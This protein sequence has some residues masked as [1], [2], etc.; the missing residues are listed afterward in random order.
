MY[1]HNHNYMYIEGATQTYISG[2]QANYIGRHETWYSGG[3]IRYAEQDAG[4]SRGNVNV[5]NNKAW[6]IATANERHA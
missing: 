4:I 5:V 1:L 2:N 3:R 6:S